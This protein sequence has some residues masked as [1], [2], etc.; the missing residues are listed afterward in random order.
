M[1]KQKSCH[2]LSFKSFKQNQLFCY[3]QKQRGAK[4]I[5]GTGS[6][7]PQT[8]CQKFPEGTVRI[9]STS[10]VHSNTRISRTS[11]GKHNGNFSVATSCMYANQRV[12]KQSSH[13][14]LLRGDALKRAFTI[15]NL[16]LTCFKMMTLIFP[17][18]SRIF[19]SNQH[20]KYS[21][22]SEK[23]KKKL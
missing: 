13:T 19:S 2:F 9:E 5:R 7:I 21:S 15:R 23:E 16:F 4:N 8:K 18:I 22:S 1:H 20:P 10:S 3:L 12:Q 17:F 14:V 6:M 11:R